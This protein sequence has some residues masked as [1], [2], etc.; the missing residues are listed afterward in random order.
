MEFRKHLGQCKFNDCD[1]LSEPECAITAAAERG[2]INPQRI[3][4]YRKLVTQLLRK[5][6]RWD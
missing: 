5:V 4:S 6:K 3:E 1:H 2:D